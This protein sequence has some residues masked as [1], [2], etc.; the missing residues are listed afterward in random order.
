MWEILPE[1]LSRSVVASSAGLFAKVRGPLAG[2]D[3]KPRTQ[4]TGP[5]H[6][7]SSVPSQKFA[8]QFSPRSGR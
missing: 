6:L 3:Q 7:Q 2:N 8:E 1:F 5:R 4:R